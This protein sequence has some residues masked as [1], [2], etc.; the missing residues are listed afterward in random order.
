VAIK[1]NRFS[2]HSKNRETCRNL[3]AENCIIL[4]SAKEYQIDSRIY[5]PNV[6]KECVHL[7]KDTPWYPISGH[8]NIQC[9]IAG[10][11]EAVS[12]IVMAGNK[13]CVDSSALQRE[14][15]V[16]DSLFGSAYTK[17]GMYEN[18]FDHCQFFTAELFFLYTNRC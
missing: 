15:R 12:S 11:W 7:S 13:I 18:Y 1:Y 17:I 2:R 6:R 9:A 8:R 4:E 5:H 10:L 3:V 14:G 16:H